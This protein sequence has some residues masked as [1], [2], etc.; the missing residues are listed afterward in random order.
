[1]DR[2]T[3][4]EIRVNEILHYR[5]D[6]IGIWDQPSA[7]DEYDSYAAQVVSAVRAGVTEK[8]VRAMLARF[9]VENM[10]LSS[11]TAESAEESV[12]WAIFEAYEFSKS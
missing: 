1:M 12:V 4:F 8:D 10:G 9:R 5:W 3:A 6:P 7:R 11:P 2:E